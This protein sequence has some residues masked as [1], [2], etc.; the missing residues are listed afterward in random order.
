MSPGLAWFLEAIVALIVAM[1]LR[2]HG[3]TIY[4]S[5]IAIAQGKPSPNCLRCFKVHETTRAGAVEAM[6][7]NR[8]R[9][10]YTHLGGS[11]TLDIQLVI[12]VE[13]AGLVG[14]T[15]I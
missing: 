15:I 6:R 13:A 9:L 7:L 8:A 14:I 10:T 11:K 12:L 3:S 5:N 1:Q 4:S 2:W